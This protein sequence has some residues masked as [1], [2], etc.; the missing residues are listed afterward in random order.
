MR[1]SGGEE[2]NRPE[3]CERVDERL[4]AIGEKV[5]GDFQ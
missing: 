5:F 3:L 1:Y 4:C 2:D